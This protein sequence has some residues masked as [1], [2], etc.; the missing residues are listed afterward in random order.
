MCKVE[1]NYKFIFHNNIQFNYL[2]KLKSLQYGYKSYSSAE[3]KPLL[4]LIK[5]LCIHIFIDNYSQKKEIHIKV[6]PDFS[7]PVNF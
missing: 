4:S 6:I 7:A 5:T 1:V 2:I 3:L